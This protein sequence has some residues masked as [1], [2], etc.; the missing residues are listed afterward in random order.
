MKYCLDYHATAHYLWWEK[1]V[2]Y[3]PPFV[4]KLL[5][6]SFITPIKK[7]IYDIIKENWFYEY[8][9]TPSNV[10][11]DFIKSIYCNSNIL[12]NLEEELFSQFELSED[13]LNTNYH[14]IYA[15]VFHFT[16]LDEGDELIIKWLEKFGIESSEYKTEELNES[17]T[18]IN[19][20][21]NKNNAVLNQEPY[22]KHFQFLKNFQ[23]KN[24][25]KLKFKTLV[26]S[27]KDNTVL[28]PICF[29][30]IKNSICVSD[31]IPDNKRGYYE[32]LFV[33]KLLNYILDYNYFETEDE[34][35]K[36]REHKDAGLYNKYLRD[37][38]RRIL[39]K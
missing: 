11:L 28:I 24:N 7:D 8:P 36:V 27:M 4:S 20:L 25:N 5:P 33:A 37:K 19:S 10:I 13:Y 21:I 29:S 32:N 2:N 1:L 26:K 23:F 31:P 12:Q 17:I 16:L 34:Y 18:G 38:V 30:K 22:F 14:E 39:N 9:C 3:I 15:M 35:F 6:N